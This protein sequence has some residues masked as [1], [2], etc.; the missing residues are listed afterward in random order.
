VKLRLR[1]ILRTAVVVPA[2]P[3]W[4]GV[5]AR[6][7]QRVAS[8]EQLQENR[9]QEATRQLK[10]ESR[11]REAGVTHLIQRT[12]DLQRD[13]DE[14]SDQLRRISAQLVAAEQRIADLERTPVVV[15]GSDTE[16]HE[17]RTLIHEVRT[18]HSRARAELAAVA[19]YEERIAR[20]ERAAEAGRR[21]EEQR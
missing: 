15:P 14:F 1:N 4:R 6:I 5:L 17:A 11:A 19:F 2:R 10:D 13:I 18:E 7:E 16:H 9:L 8:S 21:R 12:Q 20:L 3:V